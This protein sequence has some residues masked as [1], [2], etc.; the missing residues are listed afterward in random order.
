MSSNVVIKAISVL[1]LL[2]SFYSVAN[3][4]KDNIDSK[5]VAETLSIKS[6][7]QT[8]D[9]RNVSLSPDGKHIAL[10]RNQND[11][12]V[13]I[14]VDAATMQAVNQISFAKKDSVGHYYGRTMIDCLFS[15]IPSKEMKKEKLTTVK[16]TVSI[17]TKIKVNSF[18][19]CVH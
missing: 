15:F 19:V 13:I 18:L 14:I 10:I 1:F 2:I 17:L 9:Y 3:Q 6:L 12:P 4:S 11:V 8:D 16:F 5:S 7:F